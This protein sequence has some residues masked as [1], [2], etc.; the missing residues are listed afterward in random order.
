MV[1]FIVTNLGINLMFVSI[2]YF[3]KSKIKQL[4]DFIVIK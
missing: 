1:H 3:S 2:Y 4:D